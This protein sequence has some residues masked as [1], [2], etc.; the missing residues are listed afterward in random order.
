MNLMLVTQKVCQQNRTFS[1]GP[2][3]KQKTKKNQI[4]CSK[5]L[6]YVILHLRITFNQVE[7]QPLNF[8]R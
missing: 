4:N 2:S 8:D 7:V 1:E 5:F 3:P 6:S